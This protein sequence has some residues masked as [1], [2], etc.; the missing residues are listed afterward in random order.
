MGFAVERGR[1][2]H[3]Q[4]SRKLSFLL[5]PPDF[6][7]LPAD[8]ALP[9]A[10]VFCRGDRERPLDA[11]LAALEALSRLLARAELVASAR[12][13]TPRAGLR[14]RCLLCLHAAA[15]SDDFL[16]GA[17]APSERCG[18]PYWT[19]KRVFYMSIRRSPTLEIEGIYEE[20]ICFGR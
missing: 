16:F 12:P 20:E 6:V 1:L 9:E 2:H 7:R 5:R 8:E 18:S 15:A 10:D 17:I 4:F 19:T 3:I 13:T 14:L 11:T